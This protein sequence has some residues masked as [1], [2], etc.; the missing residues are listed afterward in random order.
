MATFANT[1]NP[2]PFGIYDSE[3]GFQSDADNMVTYVKRKL[4]DDILSVELT[5]KQVWMCFEESVFEFGK[6][7]IN[8]IKTKSTT[9]SNC[10]N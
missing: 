4:G 9:W 8:A 3:S 5:N 6:F 10:C 2:T 1:T 7:G